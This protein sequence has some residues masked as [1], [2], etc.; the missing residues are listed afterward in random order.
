MFLRK[1]EA[2]TVEPSTDAAKTQIQQSCL[3][4]ILVSPRNFR[5]SYKPLPDCGPEQVLVEVEGCGVCASSLPVWQGRP[6]FNYPLTPGSPGH[7]AW[8]RIVFCGG[9]VRHLQPGQRVACLA[10]QGYQEHL[11][12]DAHRLLP[13]PD[14]LNA[15]PF[16][17]EAIACAMN[18][19]RRADI[20]RG[21][22]VAIVGAGFLGL[23]V[24]QLAVDAGAEVFVLSRRACARAR[25]S[26]LGA[27]ASFDT[28]DW[29][30]STREVLQ[31]TGG[32]GCDRVIEATGLQ[33]A[34][35]AATEMIAEYGRL[36][37]AGY[38]QDGL[39]QIN[40][41]QWNWKAIDVINAHERDP[42]RYLE[43]MK[44]GIQ[45]TVEGRIQPHHLLTHQFRF[46][47]LNEAF[48]AAQERPTGF[49]KAWVSP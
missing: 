44:L 5:Y 8:G 11:V 4:A 19:F 24:L 10:E 47:Q 49:I 15:I 7:E 2:D 27:R 23:L 3:T 43:G 36:I 22:S 25:A 6:W 41:Q 21:Q 26:E 37:I 29:W 35:D 48:R 9:K 33:F 31:L 20:R 1:E 17:G 12:V 42:E 30:S 32:R 40:M 13:L 28:E 45:A 14:S 18:I 46:S 16:P 39:R 38:H 34:L